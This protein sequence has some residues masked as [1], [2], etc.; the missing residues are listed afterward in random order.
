MAK[1]QFPERPRSPTLQY[2]Y[3]LQISCKNSVAVKILYNLRIMDVIFMLRRPKLVVG[4]SCC[5]VM[6]LG[7]MVCMSRSQTPLG[8]HFVTFLTILSLLLSRFF[9]IPM[10]GTSKQHMK[11]QQP[12]NYDFRVSQFD[13]PSSRSGNDREMDDFSSWPSLRGEYYT[14]NDRQ[15]TTIAGQQR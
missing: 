14:H 9:P 15:T 1:N 4:Q 11:L 3:H 7:R 12:R 5:N 6:V 8:N 13:P 2:R 10:W